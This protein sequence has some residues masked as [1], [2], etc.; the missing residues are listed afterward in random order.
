VPPSEHGASP[1][2][3]RVIDRALVKDRELRYQRASELAAAFAA[4]CAD[5]QV[6]PLASTAGTG[7][8]GKHRGQVAMAATAHAAPRSRRLLLL[9]AVTAVAVA[10]ALVAAILRHGHPRTPE[11]AR[12]AP[13][14]PAAAVVVPP[15]PAVQPPDAA[16]PPPAPERR[17]QH[18]PASRPKRSN[19]H[20]TW[21]KTDDPF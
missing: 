2:F 19:V 4:A 9:A 6:D 13:E 15:P 1:A 21:G 12:P 16:P 11:R 14:P 3:D 8:L 5:H 7:P 10:A 17:R 20:S 18:R